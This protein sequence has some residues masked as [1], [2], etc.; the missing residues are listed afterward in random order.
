MLQATQLIDVLIDLVEPISL[1]PR[2]ELATEAKLLQ[3]ARRQERITEVI[4]YPLM[5]I[6]IHDMCFRLLDRFTPPDVE[7]V[8]QV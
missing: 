6:R 4:K 7:P 3:L 8:S 1:G 5:L 2:T